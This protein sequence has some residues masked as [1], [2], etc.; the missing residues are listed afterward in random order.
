MV[1]L[2]KIVFST[3]PDL[4]VVADVGQ[5]DL[6]LKQLLPVATPGFQIV[7]LPKIYE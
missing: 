3:R 4:I 6:A 5:R 2:R 7:G 1:D